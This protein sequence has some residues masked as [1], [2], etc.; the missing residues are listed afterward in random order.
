MNHEG[1][2]RAGTCIRTLDVHLGEFIRAHDVGIADIHFSVTELVTHRQAEQLGRAKR[3]GIELDGL[4]GI[5]D[6]P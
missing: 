1:R 4:G 3:R 6:G 2:G 5:I